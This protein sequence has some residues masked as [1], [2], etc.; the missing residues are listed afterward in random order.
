MTI[1]LSKRPHRPFRPANIMVNGF[2]FTTVNLVAATDVNVTWAN[3][4]RNVELTVPLGW[5]DATVSPE[6]GQTTSVILQRAADNTIITQFD[7]LTG[8]SYTF[9]RLPSQ[10]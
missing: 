8:T 4:N 6:V 9:P 1:T 5:T 10:V 7:N 3:R 2:A